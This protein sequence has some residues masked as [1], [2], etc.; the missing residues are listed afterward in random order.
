MKHSESIKEFATAL[1]KAQG[2]MEGAKKDAANPFFKSK[3][4]DLAS[5]IDVIR[6]PFAKNGL[7]YMQF[8]RVVQVEG[9]VSV[10]VETLV[11][12]NSGEWISES[13]SMPVVKYDPQ[14][15]GSTITYAKRY[16]LQAAAGVPS[17]DDDGNEASG[18]RSKDD[19]HKPVPRNGKQAQGED[20]WTAIAKQGMAKLSDAFAKLTADQKVSLKPRL[21]KELKPLAIAVDDNRAMESP[22]A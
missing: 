14:G 4:A 5:V 3:Y 19:D 6:A 22:H 7:S 10:E 17:E 13:L 15:I 9:K 21:D 18:N 16:G 8:P 20:A 1:S 11:M 2:E 12:H